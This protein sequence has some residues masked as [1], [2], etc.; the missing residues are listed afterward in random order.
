VFAC[1]DETTGA[2]A[3][4]WPPRSRE[5]DAGRARV[6]TCGVDTSDKSSRSGTD[7]AAREIQG[8][9]RAAKDALGP[10][11]LQGGRMEVDAPAAPDA[12]SADQQLKMSV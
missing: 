10:Q 3:D 1:N 4:L 8:P 2:V 9:R 12:G 11:Q 6:R 7:G 5:T